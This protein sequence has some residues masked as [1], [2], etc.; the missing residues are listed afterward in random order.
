MGSHT[1]EKADDDSAQS[2]PFETIDPEMEK[3]WYGSHEFREF[4]IRV[5]SGEFSG[6]LRRLFS[7]DEEAIQRSFV[8]A[9]RQ[10]QPSVN[11]VVEY[12]EAHKVSLGCLAS[13][14][15]EPLSYAATSPCVPLG[16]IRA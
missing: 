4:V 1:S 10:D 13:E 14:S 15:K 6:E 16:C 7:G 3:L 5:C 12:A 2:S 8:Y 11:F 9:F